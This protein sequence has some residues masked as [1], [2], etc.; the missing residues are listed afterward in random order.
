MYQEH[1]TTIQRYAQA[2]ADNL[3]HVGQFVAFTIHNQFHVSVGDVQD[4]RSQ[5]YDNLDGTLLATHLV[6][7][8]LR[9]NKETLHW[10]LQTLHNSEHSEADKANHMLSYVTSE[11]PGLGLIKAGFLIQL[12]YGLSACLDTHNLKRF[13]IP[14]RTFRSDKFKELKTP[15]SRLR[16]VKQYHGACERFGGTEALWD[17]WC[18]FIADKYPHRYKNAFDVSRQHCVALD[19][20]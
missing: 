11:V 18:Q 4:Y 14:P 3:E 13:G 1:A 9:N 16:K 20:A 6:L 15:K 8:W 10:H 2:S 12:T 7:N 19:L 17:T 5:I